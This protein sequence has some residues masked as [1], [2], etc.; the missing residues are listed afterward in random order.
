VIVGSADRRM[1][2]RRADGLALG[3]WPRYAD[4]ALAGGGSLGDPDGD[5]RL[6]IAF[7]SAAGRLHCWDFGPDTYDPAYLPWFTAGRSFLRQGTVALPSIGVTPGTA[8]GGPRLSLGPNPSRGVSYVNFALPGRPGAEVDFRLYDAAGRLLRQD[9]R[10]L[11]G[12][13]AARWKVEAEGAGQELRAGLYFLEAR[14]G[15]VTARS[16]WVLV[17]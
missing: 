9:R 16:K 6:E 10:V 7:G 14:A 1:H 5:G 4:G 3:G 12:T 2:V 11:D 8:G 13:G 17:R 15:G